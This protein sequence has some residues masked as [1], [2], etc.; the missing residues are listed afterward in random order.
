MRQQ[1]LKLILV[2]LCIAGA[3]A[4]ATSQ[5]RQLKS[6][7]LEYLYPTG[8]V[9]AVSAED[10]ILTIPVRVGIAF[11]PSSTRY[12]DPF[13]ELQKQDLLARIAEA[14]RDKE[15]IASLEPL[16]STYVTPGGSFEEIDRLAAAFGLDLV[17]L[18]SYDQ[19]QFSENTNA[20]WTYL[21]VVGAFVIQGE[22]NE[23]RTVMDTVVYDIPSRALLFRSA[24]DSAVKARSTPVT[25]DRSLRQ[26]SEQSFEF[27]TDDLIANLET[28][29]QAF[30]EQVKTGTVRGKGTP[31]VEIVHAS[32][33][34]GGAVALGVVDLLF[35]VALIGLLWPRGHRVRPL[36]R[37]G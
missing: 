20:S 17:A 23:T 35:M 19:Q 13:T 25:V 10:V 3:T 28:S 30:Q 26:D 16:P 12:N 22:A 18:V 2:G 21:T 27:A 36:S 7:A 11:A 9:A 24:G 37:T 15:F 8:K 34:S 33:G 29:L 31:E 5:S 6:N 14:F 32:D 1:G 4:C